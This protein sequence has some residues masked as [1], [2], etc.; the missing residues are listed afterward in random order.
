VATIELD[1]CFQN[2]GDN[3]ETIEGVIAQL[4]A[5]HGVT[6]RVINPSGPAGGWPIVEWEGTRDQLK[7]MIK[8]HY[9]SVGPAAT[10]EDREEDAEEMLS[11]VA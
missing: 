7:S 6:G 10:D 1:T 8:A 9:A 11:G 4:S 5:E 2:W 3:P